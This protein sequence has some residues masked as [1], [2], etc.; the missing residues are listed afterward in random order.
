MHN[1]RQYFVYIL[2]NEGN[3][4]LYIGMTND[5]SRRLE[6]HRLKLVPGFTVKYNVTKLVYYEVHATA[7][8]AIER[9]K[10]L[11]G[12]SRVRKIQLV[13]SLNPTWKDLVDDLV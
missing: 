8:D 12:G 10:Q 4:V 11:K 9:E 1:E 6:E 13:E 5:L 3:G 2:T 7:M